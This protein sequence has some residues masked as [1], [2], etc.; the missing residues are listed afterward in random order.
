MYAGYELVEATARPGADEHIDSE[1]YEYKPRDW[2]KA[3]KA[4]TTIAPYITKLNEIRKLHPAVGQIR[5]LEVHG[6]SD[7]SI[8]VFTKHLSAEHSPTGKADTVIVVANLDPNNVHGADIQLDLWKLDLG[9]DLPFQV[10]DLM[11]GDSRS[12][13][14]KSYIRIDPSVDPVI[15]LR[16]DRDNQ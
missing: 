7:E 15:I 2:Q 4:G 1:K 5:T 9:Y 14:A 12:I 13:S 3:D 10:T 16:V 11:S 8:L 6:S